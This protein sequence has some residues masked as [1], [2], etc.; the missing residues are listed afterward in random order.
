MV[1]E[2]VGGRDSEGMV[3]GKMRDWGMAGR[4]F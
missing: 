3:G 2:M 1:F 4:N